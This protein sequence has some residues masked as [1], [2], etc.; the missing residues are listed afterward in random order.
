[1]PKRAFLHFIFQLLNL[2]TLRQNI[3]PQEETRHF[4][5]MDGG[6]SFQGQKLYVYKVNYHETVNPSFSLHVCVSDLC[7]GHGATR[8]T[9][10]YAKDGV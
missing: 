1:M 6:F 7:Q 10:R 5:S 4:F 8:H 3:L 9:T 2:F